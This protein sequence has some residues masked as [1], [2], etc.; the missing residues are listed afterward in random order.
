[1]TF[2]LPAALVNDTIKTI[3]GHLTTAEKAKDE[4]EKEY[5]RLRDELKAI[6]IAADKTSVKTVWGKV[7]LVSGRKSVTYTTKIKLME[8]K[9][10]AAKEQEEIS[11]KATISYGQQS[12]RLDLAK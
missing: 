6:M 11:G 3:M 7:T 2:T 8:A 4:A 1:M 12:I 9:V 10:K 5:N